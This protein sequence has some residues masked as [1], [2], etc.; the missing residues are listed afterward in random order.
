MNN[1][2]LLEIYNSQATSNTS[3]SY[4]EYSEGYQE[5]TCGGDHVDWHDDAWHYDD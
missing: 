4:T 5:G 2:Q 3:S 1:E